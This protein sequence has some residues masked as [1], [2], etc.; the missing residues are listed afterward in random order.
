[1][2]QIQPARNEE[3]FFDLP[4]TGQNFEEALRGAGRA[5]ARSMER[6]HESIR[7]CVDSL[8]SDGMECEAALLTIKAFV[9]DVTLKHRRAGSS[10]M[11]HCDT[12]MDQVVRW[13]ISD[14]YRA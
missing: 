12:L 2:P 7:K 10:D 6:L 3:P 5:D 1:M 8:R 13:C 14:F 11:L 9:K 4:A